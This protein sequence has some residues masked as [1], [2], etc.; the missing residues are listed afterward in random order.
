MTEPRS[1]RVSA[2]TWRTAADFLQCGV[3]VAHLIQRADL[4]L[5]GEQD[6]DVALDQVEEGV[7]MPVHAEG[8]GQRERDLAP[9]RVRQAGRRTEG[10]LSIRRIEEIALEVDDLRARDEARVDVPGVR[11]PKRRG[12]CSS[13]AAR[14]A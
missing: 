8:I 9:R 3:E 12:T 4:G 7:A 11:R 1:L 6:V 14:P 5:V 2:A 13:S 10:F